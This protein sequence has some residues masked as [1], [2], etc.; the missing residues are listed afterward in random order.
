MSGITKGE[1][2]HEDKM[3]GAICVSQ[4]KDEDQ[5][6]DGH[7]LVKMSFLHEAMR[8]VFMWHAKMRRRG[9]VVLKYTLSRGVCVVGLQ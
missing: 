8:L 1:D 2:V 7:G 6:E 3:A 9:L 4:R 5:R